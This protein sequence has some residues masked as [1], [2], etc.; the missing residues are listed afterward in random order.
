[1]FG[2]DQ[3]LEA[4]STLTVLFYNMGGMD[5]EVAVVRYSLMDLGKKTAPYIEILAEAS[6]KDLGATD[7]D[8]ALTRLLAEKF[9]ALPERE[10]KPSVLTNVRATKRLQKEAVKIKEI[11]SANKQASVK[12]PELLDTVTLKVLLGRDELDA[13]AQSVYDRVAAP[14]LEALTKAGLKASEVDQIELIGGGVRIPRVLEMLE[15]ALERK[16]L[17]VHLNG[18]EA[19]CFGSAFIASNSSSSFKVKSVLVTQHPEYDIHLKISPTKP[20]EAISEDD[21]KAEGLEE[22]D[23]IKYTQEIRLFDQKKDYMGKSKGLSMNYN[24]DMTLEFF[25]VS[26]SAEGEESL[27]LIDTFHLEDVQKQYE[28]E[29]KHQVDEHK[30]EKD[31]AKRAAAK[32]AEKK[33]KEEEKKAEEEA[34]KDGDAEGEG[35]KDDKKEKP[36]MKKK[37]KK[38]K[39]KKEDKKEETKEEET[40]D[41]YRPTNPKLKL[42][43]EF[44]RSGYL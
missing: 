17:A 16:D 1:M 25:R 32:E 4:N 18:D 35:D 44:S 20:A 13:A 38:D 42:S 6:S 33:E 41:D 43:I 40:P 11:L 34:A 37:K 19:M 27:E 15:A 21:Q 10:G 23:I 31:R 29:L 30:F 3:K 12:I 26:T 8:L 9:D 28:S 5:T 24:K 39:K 7:V 36:D 14:A 22:T 2:I